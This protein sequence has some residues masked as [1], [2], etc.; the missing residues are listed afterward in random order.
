MRFVI[1]FAALLTLTVAIRAEDKPWIDLTASKDYSVWKGK[2]A[3]WAWAESVQI[4]EKNPKKLTAKPGNNILWNGEK[5]RA[6]DLVTKQSFGDLEIH[7]EFLIPKGSNSGVKF[8]AVYEIQIYDSY[9]KKELT[10]EDCG[11]IYPRADAKP[12]YHH[13]DKGIAPKVNACKPPGEWQTL[14]AIFLSPRFDGAGKKTTNAKIVKAVLNG[15][16]IHENQEMLTPTGNNW[17]KPE[18]ASGPLLLQG[19]HG[20]VAF[21]KV[22]VREYAAGK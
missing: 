6:K 5:G 14:D 17:D 2:V 21:R 16:V 10:G 20:P 13:L 18:V 9:G 1:A 15:Q 12:K 8:H 11:G 19:D 7:V 22:R 4:D 3:D